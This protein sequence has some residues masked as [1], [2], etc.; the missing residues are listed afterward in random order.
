MGKPVKDDT[1]GNGKGGD[2]N[3][4]KG[5]GKPS[6]DNVID[7]TANADFLDSGTDGTDVV[8][9]SDGSDWIYT[10]AGDDMIDAGGG[11]DLI[12][13]GI[14]NDTI[15]GGDG[16]DTV[17]YDFAID[18]YTITTAGTTAGATT[19]VSYSVG[20]DSYTDTLTGVESIIINQ[21]TAGGAAGSTV[22]FDN[23][24]V[25]YG[26]YQADT[27]LGPAEV[28][29][30]G[31]GL[32]V[33]ATVLDT[34]G[35]FPVGGVEDAGTRVVDHDTD[36]DSEFRISNDAAASGLSEEVNIQ[37]SFD[38]GFAVTGFTLEDLDH[39]TEQVLLSLVQDDPVG[40]DYND[41][42][43]WVYDITALDAD[44]DGVFTAAELAA[45]PNLD[46]T[47]IDQF[48]LE[49]SDGGTFYLDDLPIA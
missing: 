21:Q 7:G 45:D 35:F 41:P 42:T 13:P 24:G 8:T 33:L 26:L 47:D 37:S 36:G 27:A 15:E 28:I 22:T 6:K 23:L 11:D 31:S 44:Q 38:L 48:I 49:T 17:I 2:G 9:G 14:G 18:S 20:G 29:L 25:D 16:I 19:T 39:A 1:K 5:G 32:Y 43:V 30:T 34:T 12:V 4:G 3:P 46:L 10:F 40:G